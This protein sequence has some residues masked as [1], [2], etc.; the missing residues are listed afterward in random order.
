MS[1]YPKTNDKIDRDSINVMQDDVSKD[2][3]NLI[4]S[5]I[6]RGSVG[7]DVLN[8]SIIYCARN[9]SVNERTSGQ[10]IHSYKAFP[11][12]IGG[13]HWDDANYPIGS[14]A[15][16]SKHDSIKHREER[17]DWSVINSH[18]SST[19]ADLADATVTEQITTPDWEGTGIFS[20]AGV[21][22]KNPFGR[23]MFKI[24]NHGRGYNILFHTDIN[25][26]FATTN[27]GISDMI[28]FQ[29]LAG[30]RV[31]T[32]VIYA[33]KP[34]RNS[35]R[36]LCWSPAHMLGASASIN[37]S[38]ITNN[39][40]SIQK[41]HSYTDVISVNDTFIRRLCDAQ[42]IDFTD[43]KMHLDE[44]SSFGWTVVGCLDRWDEVPPDSKEL[45]YNPD[46]YPNKD[47]IEDH[48][49]QEPQLTK[50]QRIQVVGGNTN[51]IAFKDAENGSNSL[52]NFGA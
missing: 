10:K 7:S 13:E 49:N 24:P 29:W 8:D 30:Q 15:I 11:E 35:T 38:A 48:L 22:F 32:S 5:T 39:S 31:W 3:N 18:S 9:F 25:I 50:A 23:K 40:R 27:K 16:V 33:L 19:L 4:S 44:T 52:V 26:A 51:F 6:G 14:V 12:T 45:A 37:M 34:N 42:G 47:F 43:S 21:R 20:P 17:R 36:V 41:T 1:I 46:I 28:W 2:A